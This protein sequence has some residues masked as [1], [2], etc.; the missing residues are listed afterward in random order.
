MHPYNRL[1]HCETGMSI[2]MEQSSK[3]ERQ[4]GFGLIVGAVL[5]AIAAGGI[6]WWR[7]GGSVFNEMVLAGLAW[8]F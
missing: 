2:G 4:A 8:C 5:C 3:Q 6:M 7:Y 1:N